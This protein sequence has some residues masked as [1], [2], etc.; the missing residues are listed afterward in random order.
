M[1]KGKM[2]GLI[3]TVSTE[4]GDNIKALI[5]WKN[6]LFYVSV[7]LHNNTTSILTLYY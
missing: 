3:L 1:R 6:L 5:C 7:L 4:E 2:E